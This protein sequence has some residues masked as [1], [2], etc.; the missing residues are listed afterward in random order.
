[1]FVN[2]FH[3]LFLSCKW[4]K[5]TLLEYNSHLPVSTTL[6]IATC[7]VL[8]CSCERIGNR[9]LHQYHTRTNMVDEDTRVD[10]DNEEDR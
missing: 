1:M 4:V 9:S 10:E 5:R 6:P 8:Q 7:T 3:K 2:I